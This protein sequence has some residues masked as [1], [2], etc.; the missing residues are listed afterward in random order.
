MTIQFIYPEIGVR[1]WIFRDFSSQV[2]ITHL[3]QPIF[4]FLQQI[5]DFRK[6]DSVLIELMIFRNFVE[7]DWIGFN[8]VRSVWTRTE[9]FYN[10]LILASLCVFAPQ[11]ANIHWHAIGTKWSVCLLQES[12]DW[13]CLGA[14]VA[15]KLAQRLHVSTVGQSKV[16]GKHQASDTYKWLPCTWKYE[17]SS[18]DSSGAEL[19]SG[20]LTL[21]SFL[22]FF[23]ELTHASLVCCTIHRFHLSLNITIILPSVRSLLR[24][25]RLP[26]VHRHLRSKLL[27]SFLISALVW[28]APIDQTCV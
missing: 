17:L 11:L 23:A 8:F 15:V 28:L 3:K 6:N 4:K 19:T 22:K 12:I 5:N 21:A 27:A 26:C 7:Q 18:A 10:P 9:T 24:A 20:K 13:M 25:G 14:C 1:A 16:E 2:K